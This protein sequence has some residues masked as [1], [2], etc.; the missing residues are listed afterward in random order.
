MNLALLFFLLMKAS[1]TSFSGL[2]SL[3]ILHAD[4]VEHYHVLTDAQLNT[5]VTAGRGGPGPIGIY[6]VCVGYQVAGLPG[7]VEGFIA[8][9]SPAFLIVV[10]LKRLGHIADRPAVRGAIQS[11]VIAAAG[12][13]AAVALGLAR[14]GAHDA[15]TLIVAIAAFAA[16][17]LTKI[18]SAW[19]MLAAALLGLARAL[20]P[21]V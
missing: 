15:F 13:L 1:F 17:S 9:V 12:M 10:L 7:A 4:L 16:L 21:G 18:E 8:C 19:V 14:S 5:A 11:V 6:I 3:P 2:G 20:L